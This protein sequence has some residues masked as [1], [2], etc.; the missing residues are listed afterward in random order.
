M[1]KRIDW[2]I[3]GNEI[4]TLYQSGLSVRD[5]VDVMQKSHGAVYHS[6][7][8][9]GYLGRRG[10]LRS[11]SEAHKLTKRRQ[12]RTCEL[13][14]RTYS[15][16]SYNQRWCDDC[17]G[18]GRYVRRVAAHGLPAVVLEHAFESQEG[19]C[20]ICQRVFSSFLNTRDKKT[21]FVD[22]DHE[23]MQFRGLLCPRC[24]SGLSFLDDKEWYNA[25]L[26]YKL[27]ATNTAQPI[28]THPTRKWKYVRGT[29]VPCINNDIVEHGHTL[30][31]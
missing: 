30:K 3:H 11:K 18:K 5:I 25:A 17:T 13:C 6:G 27:A 20:A 21:L 15:A 19:K 24:N 31:R 8:L 2:S 1:K 26:G 23:S 10:V 4:V 7:T 28:Y 9:T 22:H 29:K 12:E 14:T 16:S